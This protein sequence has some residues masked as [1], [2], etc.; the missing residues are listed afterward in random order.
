MAEYQYLWVASPA[1]ATVWG[2]VFV[3]AVDGPPQTAMRR[4]CEQNLHG[5]EQPQYPH[6]SSTGMSG[7]FEPEV[8]VV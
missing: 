3:A 7:S 2:V 6:P 5:D 1:S 8:S 4:M